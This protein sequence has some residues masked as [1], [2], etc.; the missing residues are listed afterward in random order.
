MTF[1]VP[2]AAILAIF[3]ENKVKG[4][5]AYRA[6]A[7]VTLTDGTQVRPTLRQAKLSLEFEAE[8]GWGIPVALGEDVAADGTVDR[9]FTPVPSAR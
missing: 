8:F 9:N 2:T 4:I 1:P 3:A 6:A 5:K 7:V